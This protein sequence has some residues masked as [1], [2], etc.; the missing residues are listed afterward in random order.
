[1]SDD[2]RDLH[3]VSDA[4]GNNGAWAPPTTYKTVGDLVDDLVNKGHSVYDRHDDY[5][6]LKDELPE[7]LLKARLEDV[8][9]GKF[10]DA[11]GKIIEQAEVIIPMV[12]DMQ[13]IDPEIDY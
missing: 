7:E 2:L 10:E 5:L 6:G 12:Q 11:V 4:L 9:E 13:V 1:M 8:D 3:D